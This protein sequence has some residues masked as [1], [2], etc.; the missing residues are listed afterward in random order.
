M[1]QVRMKA[2]EMLENEFKIDKVEKLKYYEIKEEF[3]SIK[4]IKDLSPDA[5]K[6]VKKIYNINHYANRMN[7]RK[8]NSE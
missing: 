3:E 2:L 6:Y 7:K 8:N 4:R 1:S 5:Y